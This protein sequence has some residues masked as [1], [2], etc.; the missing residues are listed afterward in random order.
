MLNWNIQ[1]ED[2]IIYQLK[3]DDITKMDY[4]TSQYYPQFAPFITPTFIEL[5]LMMA[6]SIEFPVSVYALVFQT[7]FW[8]IT[9]FWTCHKSDLTVIVILPFR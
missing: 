3:T 8:D 2:S 4:H 7:P 9:H 1:S 6:I 5:S